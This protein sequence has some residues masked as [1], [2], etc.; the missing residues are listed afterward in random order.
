MM[1]INI[2]KDYIGRR[3]DKLL[4][5][6]YGLLQSKICVLAKQK[7]IL[8]NGE[9]VKFDYRI[10]KNDKIEVLDDVK[11]VKRTVRSLKKSFQRR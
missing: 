6:K 9:N 2:D 4:R 1:K 10:K 3:I 11:E 5:D 8:V 7:K